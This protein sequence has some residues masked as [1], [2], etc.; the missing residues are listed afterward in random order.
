MF[1]LLKESYLQTRTTE[2]R[3]SMIKQFFGPLS[4]HVL[5]YLD[6]AHDYGIDD[7]FETAVNN[8]E[9]F[10]KQLHGQTL[11]LNSYLFDMTP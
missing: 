1:Q 10:D 11:K 5:E 7:D 2:H 9:K 4:T 6:S 3:N 8:V